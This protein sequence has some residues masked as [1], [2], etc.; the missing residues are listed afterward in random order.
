MD[1]E[2]CAINTRSDCTCYC[3]EITEINEKHR[4]ETQE[5]KIKEGCLGF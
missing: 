5:L 1:C 2:G 3:S 4:K